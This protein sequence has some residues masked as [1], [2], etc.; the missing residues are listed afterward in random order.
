MQNYISNFLPQKNLTAL[1]K[2]ASVFL[3]QIPFLTTTDTNSYITQ[4]EMNYQKI[5]SY[6]TEFDCFILILKTCFNSCLREKS[7]ISLSSYKFSFRIL[8]SYPYYLEYQMAENS[9]MSD[10]SRKYL[11]FI[12]YFILKSFISEK[13]FEKLNNLMEHWLLITDPQKI[14]NNSYK[15][16]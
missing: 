3:S 9:L 13:E 14:W 15:H 1:N 8:L 10:I 7:Y 11:N 2:N 16:G 4:V 12:K 6:K 5:P